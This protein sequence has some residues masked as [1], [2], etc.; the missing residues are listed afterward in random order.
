VVVAERS[1]PRPRDRGGAA[2]RDQ[3]LGGVTLIHVWTP[4]EI[5]AVGQFGEDAGWFYGFFRVEGKLYFGEIFPGY[6]GGAACWPWPWWDPRAWYRAIRDV[7][8]YRPRVD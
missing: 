4:A 8:Y 2:Q 7:M 6:G 3:P 1:S 5:D